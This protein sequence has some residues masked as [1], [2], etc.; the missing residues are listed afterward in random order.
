MRVCRCNRRCNQGIQELRG[1]W[2]GWWTVRQTS[3]ERPLLSGPQVIDFSMFLPKKLAGGPGFEPGLAESESAV[4]PLNYPPAIAANH[5]RGATRRLAPIDG[6]Y[7]ASVERLVQP[8]HAAKSGFHCAVQ[9]PS[10]RSEVP[11]TRR[12]ASLARKTT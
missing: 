5:P 4:L 9:P 8:L 12:E 3:L 11:V 7:L 10:T 1:Q 6:A 2:T